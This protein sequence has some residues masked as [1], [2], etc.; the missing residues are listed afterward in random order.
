[1][2]TVLRALLALVLVASLDGCVATTYVTG[3]INRLEPE[4]CLDEPT[5]AWRSPDGRALYVR[6][7][8]VKAISTN[9]V[10][11]GSSCC[12]DLPDQ[13]AVYDADGAGK[14][15]RLVP[16]KGFVPPAGSEEVELERAAGGGGFFVRI[17]ETVRW[18]SLS[19]KKTCVT[20]RIAHGVTMP[21]TLALD[22]AFFP[23]ELVALWIA[24][25]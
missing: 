13:V 12:E 11:W 15:A 8:Q 25:G 10:W 24:F 4:V 3:Q 17:G 18:I 2:K 14:I 22:A 5:R 7:T 16:A 1:M 21:A 9:P 19:I 23:V 6:A 20:A